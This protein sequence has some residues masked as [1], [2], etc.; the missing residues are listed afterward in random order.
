MKKLIVQLLCY[1]I[2]IYNNSHND[3]KMPDTFSIEYGA[4]ENK[5]I[6]NDNAIIS[7]YVWCE[8]YYPYLAYTLSENGTTITYDIEISMYYYTYIK[9]VREYI[10]TCNDNYIR[11]ISNAFIYTVL[12]VDAGD[13][14]FENDRANSSWFDKL[15]ELLESRFYTLNEIDGTLYNSGELF[16]NRLIELIHQENIVIN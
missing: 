11:A 13:I 12:V 15:A 10:A 9:R 5:L 16:I 2:M 6:C 4:Y 3:Y 14:I 8:G 1:G 7:W